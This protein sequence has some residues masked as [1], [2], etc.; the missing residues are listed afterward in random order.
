MT[1]EIED[2]EPIGKNKSFS[3]WMAMLARISIGLF[4]LMAI[5]T[6]VFGVSALNGSW[7][8]AMCMLNGVAVAAAILSI[9]THK[10]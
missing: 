6:L 5:S 4:T 2:F 3:G 7:N 8:V 9:A 10:P 1:D